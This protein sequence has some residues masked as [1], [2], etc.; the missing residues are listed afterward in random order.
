MSAV[1]GVGKSIYDLSGA[2]LRQE[3]RKEV[4]EWILLTTGDARE[5]AFDEHAAGS[6]HPTALTY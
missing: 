5:V 4:N 1:W 3:K 6:L 2:Y